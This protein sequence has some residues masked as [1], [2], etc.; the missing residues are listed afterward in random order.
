MVVNYLW[1]RRRR[2]H[3]HI[4]LHVCRPCHEGWNRWKPS[5]RRLLQRC[6]S[7]CMSAKLLYCFPAGNNDAPPGDG[8]RSAL[9]GDV[10]LTGL[11]TA[12]S[13]DS[14]MK[15]VAM[16]K[17]FLMS[18]GHAFTV[19]FRPFHFRRSRTAAL[20]PLHAALIS[21]LC[22]HVNVPVPFPGTGK[23]PVLTI[24]E[25]GDVDAEAMARS[26]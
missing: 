19:S 24:K 5:C 7:A 6:I 8:S 26:G 20:A 12:A 11:S 13:S 25:C 17:A 1:R 4:R 3:V 23:G 18:S 2:R 14:T 21:C 22:A 16:S 15:R 10:F 9:M